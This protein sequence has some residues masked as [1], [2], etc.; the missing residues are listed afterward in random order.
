MSRTLRAAQA[1]VSVAMLALAACAAPMPKPAALPPAPPALDASY[2]WRVLTVAPFGSVLRDI[3]LTLHEVLLFR[4]EARSATAADELE[5]YAVDGERPRFIARTPA[6][7]L[8]CFKHDRLSRIEATVRL[9]A[10]E[11]ARIFADAC[12]L[13]RNSGEAAA[14]G[15]AGSDGGIAYSGHL[16]SEPDGSETRMSVQLNAPAPESERA[17][18]RLPERP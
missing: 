13:W 1:I 17:P 8:L 5:C 11:A 9:P 4:D 2:D 3:P 16:D 7:Y 6:E 18:E 12:G 14:E 15:C 10:D